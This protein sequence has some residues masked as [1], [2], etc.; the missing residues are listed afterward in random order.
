[1]LISDL[2]MMM[3]KCLICT[4]IIEVLVSVILRVKNKKDILNIIIVNIMT[5]PLVTSI[6]VFLNIQFGLLER[7]VG[8][9]ILEIFTVISEGLVYKKY[10]NYKKINPYILS[11]ILNTSEK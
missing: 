4:I 1:M 8:L 7:H 6:P 5:N 11:I 10:L 9:F 2:P 3:L